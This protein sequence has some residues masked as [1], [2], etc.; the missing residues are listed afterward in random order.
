M[1]KNRR[2]APSAPTKAKPKQPRARDNRPTQT[3]RF[4]AIRRAKHRRSRLVR[5]A[6]IGT[7][8]AVVGGFIAWR[9]VERRDAKRTIEAMTRGSCRYDT[10][11]DAGRVNEHADNAQYRV[12]PPSGG[13][14][15]PSAASTGSY[16]APTAP[17]PGQVVHAL[18]HGGIAVWYDTSMAADD[19][20]KLEALAEKNSSEVLLLPSEG[21][22]RPAAATAWH[23]R[24]LCGQ[25]EIGSLQRFIDA[26]GGEG[27]ERGARLS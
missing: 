27:P 8:V 15:L 12:I 20:A 18:E 16:T 22:G 10:R 4:E 21:L 11:T 17:P 1:A 14:H 24:L 13:V 9:V 3:E 2:K 19:V 26:Y 25:I 23:R 7:A 5:F 6:A